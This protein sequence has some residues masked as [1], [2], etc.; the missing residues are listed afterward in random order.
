M[1]EYISGQEALLA[2]RGCPRRSTIKTLYLRF[3]IKYPK[4]V[5]ASAMLLLN[6][7]DHVTHKH[8][9]THRD[10]GIVALQAGPLPLLLH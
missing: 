2:L 7:D 6:R 1:D 4:D 3:L 5:W 8:T 10:R 9:H